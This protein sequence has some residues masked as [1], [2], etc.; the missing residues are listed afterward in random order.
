M[1]AFTVVATDEKGP[2]G[3]SRWPRLAFPLLAGVLVLVLGLS[4]LPV[5]GLFAP[6]RS[7]P[8]IEVS[9]APEGAAVFVNGRLAGATPVRVCD[10][11]PGIYAVRLEKQGH[12][13]FVRQVRM[14]AVS[15]TLSE[16]LAPA[17]SGR[18]KVSVS[19]PGSEVL[20]D[21]E[22]AGH[23]PLSLAS[24]PAG[25]YEMMIRKANHVPQVHR[26]NIQ[27]GETAEFKG[28]ELENSIVAA[29]RQ[30]AKDEKWRVSHLTELAH[31]LL[32]NDRQLESAVEAMRAC[33]LA[34]Q[35]LELPPEMPQA[36]REAEHRLRSDDQARLNQMLGRMWSWPG[37]DCSAFRERLEK[38]DASLVLLAFRLQIRDLG[39]ARATALGLLERFPQDA[40]TLCEA[41]RQLQAVCPALQDKERPPVLDASERL[42]RAAYAVAKSGEEK[43]RCASEWGDFIYFRNGPTAEALQRLREGVAEKA[44]EAAWE[45]RV[46]RL[47]ACLARM[48]QHPEAREWYQ[49]L[50]KSPRAEVKQ[51]AAQ[52]LAKLPK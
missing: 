1:K 27:A 13:P 32:V 10:L 42:L 20:L 15:V 30:R 26:V 28:F 33:A 4:F 35:P 18:L 47:A 23:T 36:D 51:K 17:P 41:G 14:G 22:L 31:Y 37:K 24:V 21:G 16:T 45:Q 9:S 52:E 19:P 46:F 39:S 49:K 25:A 11:A 12:L 48:K 44:D 38:P 5:G 29:I 43:A 6:S 7:G 50:A 2:G 8:W 34:C 40:A 3:R